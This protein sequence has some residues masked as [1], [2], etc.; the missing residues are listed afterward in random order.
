MSGSPICEDFVFFE[1]LCLP[2]D[3]KGPQFT[4]EP[5]TKLHFS[6]DTGGKIDCAATGIPSPLIEWIVGDGRIADTIPNLRTVY[7]NGTIT[8]F[9]FSAD[10]YRLEIHTRDYRCRARNTVGQIISKMTNVNADEDKKSNDFKYKFYEMR[11]KTISV[12][13]NLRINIS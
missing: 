6:N 1:L 4:R 7:P 12:K 3:A 8:F 2:F 9:P 11:E 5:P 13:E 10:L